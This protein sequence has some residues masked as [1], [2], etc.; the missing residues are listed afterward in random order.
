[1]AKGA[2]LFPGDRK[3]AALSAIDG[4]EMFIAFFMRRSVRALSVKRRVTDASRTLRYFIE[5]H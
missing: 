1:M 4:S 5:G 2:A 3:V